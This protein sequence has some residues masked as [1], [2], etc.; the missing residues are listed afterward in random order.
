MTYAATIPRRRIRPVDD[1]IAI[2]TAA[3]YEAQ[4]E[5]ME[6]RMSEGQR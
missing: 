5:D 2:L 1:V 3:S 4:V 6:R